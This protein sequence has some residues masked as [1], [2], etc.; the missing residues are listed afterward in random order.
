M[1]VELPTTDEVRAVV[2]EEIER[3]LDGAAARREWMNQK[4]LAEY[5]GT[6]RQNVAA[7]ARNGRIPATRISDG[8]VRYNRADV[9]AA[10]RPARRRV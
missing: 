1:S 8:T 5:L 4:E 6:S 10:L 3:A 7:L 9:D 2:R